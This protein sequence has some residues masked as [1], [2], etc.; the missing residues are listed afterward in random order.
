M[1]GMRRIPSLGD[2]VSYWCHKN[3]HV[4]HK[5]ANRSHK[6]EFPPTVSSAETALRKGKETK[7]LETCR[8]GFASLIAF[9]LWVFTN[10]ESS[11]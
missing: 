2:H 11:Y 1:E 3:R 4:A 9:V 8:A 7:G 6:E 10:Y 5:S